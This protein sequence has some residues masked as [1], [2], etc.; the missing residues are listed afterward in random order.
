VV[1]DTT[2]PLGAHAVS[3][4]FPFAADQLTLAALN[5]LVHTAHP[6]VDV[7]DFEVRETFLFGSGQVST[8]G[9]IALALTY[10][11]EGAAALP[12]EVMLKVARPELVA[13]PLY[14]NEVAFYTRLRSEL[15]SSVEAPRCVGGIYDSA[16]GTFG[17]GLEDLRVRGATFSNVKT[18]HSIAEIQSLL[19]SA[20]RLHARYWES[21]R[22]A[23]DL[24]WV[25]THRQGTLHFL[26]DESGIVPGL[27]QQQVAEVQFKRELVESVAQTPETL[28]EQV[29]R[30]QA[31]Q[32]QSPRTLVHGDLHAG[33]TYRLPDG[34]GGFVDWQLTV[35]GSFIHDVAYL[36]ITGL[37]VENRRRD[38]RQLLAYYLDC[39]RAA[40]VTSAPD[41]ETTF[42]EY[43]RAAVWGVYV[44]WLTTP[45]E[46]YGW[47]ITVLNHIRLL[48]AYRDLE[49][50]AALSTLPEV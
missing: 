13:L 8:A 9:R 43:R 36:L 15:G 31:H 37:T 35:R 18:P 29:R 24:G 33:N 48:T 47:E 7:T 50:A 16:S 4:P 23:G 27:I 46:N 49:T 38:E 34:T 44:G 20:A 39:L 6:K 26:F 30:V 10:K 25:E 3:A 1:R 12:R 45:V 5:D 2:C 11:G 14:A 19:G 40:G 41:L 21:P 22:F 17:L 42:L 32:A 28:G